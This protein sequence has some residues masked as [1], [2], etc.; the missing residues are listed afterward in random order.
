MKR[1]VILGLSVCFVL[2]CSL[3]SLACTKNC[4]PQCDNE[5]NKATSGIRDSCED[6]A[7]FY[8]RIAQLAGEK[9]PYDDA[10][11]DQCVVDS[12]ESYRQDCMNGCDKCDD[13][14]DFLGGCFIESVPGGV[15]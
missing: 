2:V 5:A 11:I 10:W 8:N 14:K 15:K 3:S 1:I 13:D 6:T 4:G 12:K 7:Y 9:I